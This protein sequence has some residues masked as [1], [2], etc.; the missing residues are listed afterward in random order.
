VS[1][2]KY[3]KHR[4]VLAGK[5][6]KESRRRRRS[7]KGYAMENPLSMTEL[8]VGGVTML[9]GA[10][11]ADVLDRFLATHAL[12]DKNAK[13]ANGNEL[14]ADPG[15]DANSAY[16]GMFNAAAIAAP[17]DMKRWIAAV[18]I[19]AAPLVVS[20]FVKSG[21]GR[22]ALQLFAFG[23]L[24]RGGGKAAKDLI[25]KFTK[26]N[27]IGQRLFDA[28]MRAAA[29]KAGDGS[30]ASLPAAGLGRQ[31][32]AFGCGRCQNC[33]T[34]VGACCGNM[35]PPPAP[36]PSLQPPG[37]WL[38]PPVPV[39]G[40]GPM[41]QPQ[42]PPPQPP[43]P[44]PPPPAPPPTGGIGGARRQAGNGKWWGAEEDNH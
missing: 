1:R 26:T 16:K 4:T 38:P 42:P 23:A 34:G 19:V 2:K 28:E 40:P 6:T 7:R 17:M 22:S 9:L 21:A 24:V 15:A 11:S 39:P 27:P 30:E 3:G 5:I 31:M 14:Y 20:G 33:R 29:L 43:P 36:G 25:A 37:N 18:G 35:A 41:P 8:F 12:Q 44:Q 10:G 13:D 32:R